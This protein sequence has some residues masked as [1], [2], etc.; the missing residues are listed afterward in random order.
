MHREIKIGRG[1]SI[2]PKFGLERRAPKR[3]S[4]KIKIRIAN[5]A[6][7][8]PRSVADKKDAR[9]VCV[10]TLAW[11]SVTQFPFEKGD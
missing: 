6:F 7:Q 1:S 4:R 11:L 8:F 9:C 10:D 2:K 5:G 3:R